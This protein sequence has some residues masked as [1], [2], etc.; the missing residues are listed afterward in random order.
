MNHRG[1]TLGYEAF[2]TF[3]HFDYSW[4]F[5]SDGG[6]DVIKQRGRTLTGF[7]FLKYQMHPQPAEAGCLKPS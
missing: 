3:P 1:G 5:V 2:I 6:L 4:L 7:P